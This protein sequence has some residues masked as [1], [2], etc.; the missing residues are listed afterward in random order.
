MPMPDDT[1]TVQEMKDYGYT[2]DGMLP[3]YVEKALELFESESFGG[4]VYLLYEDDTEG[5]AYKTSEIRRHNN[6][7]GIFGIEQEDWLSYLE[8]QKGCYNI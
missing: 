8:Q 7:G 2:W 1:I 4:Y 6:F 3:L 5:A